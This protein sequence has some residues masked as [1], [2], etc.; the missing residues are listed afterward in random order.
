M[1]SIVLKEEGFARVL[2]RRHDDERPVGARPET[3]QPAD[4]RQFDLTPR[5][6]RTKFGGL[7]L[8]LPYLTQ[9]PLAE[10]LRKS[11]FPGTK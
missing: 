3:A 2:P 9:I 6:F 8:F 5:Q 7:F 1:I 10:I 11:G 4:V